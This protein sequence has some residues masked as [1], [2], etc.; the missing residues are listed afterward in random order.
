VNA[1]PAP[2]RLKQGGADEPD[3]AFVSFFMHS[4]LLGD[5]PTVTIV[6]VGAQDLQ[7]ERHIYSPLTRVWPHRIVGFEPVHEAEVVEEDR[8]R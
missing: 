4:D 2:A 3:A 1:V 5:D 6:D 7:N 8:V